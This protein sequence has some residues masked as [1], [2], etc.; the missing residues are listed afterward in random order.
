M[1]FDRRSILLG[2]SRAISTAT[3]AS[4]LPLRHATADA[5]SSELP[6]GARSLFADING[7][8]MHY[9]RAD[10]VRGA[11]AARVAPNVVFVRRIIPRFASDYTVIAPDLRGCGQ[12]ERTESGYDKPTIAED[13]RL[14]IAYAGFE[15]HT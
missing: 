5:K 13:L 6:A 9:V 11:S 14:L 4:A 7:I 12:L 2:A 15:M 1:L 8:R 3:L 10:Q